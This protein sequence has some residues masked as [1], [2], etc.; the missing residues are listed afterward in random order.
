MSDAQLQE[1][2]ANQ[3]PETQEEILRINDDAR[4]RALQIALLVRFSSRCWDS[5]SPSE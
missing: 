3:P 5:P 1:Q 2:I 4:P